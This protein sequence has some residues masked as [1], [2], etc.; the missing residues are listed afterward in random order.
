VRVDQ[1][2]ETGGYLRTRLAKVKELLETIGDAFWTEQYSNPSAMAAHYELTAGEIVAAFSG[3]DYVFVGVSTAA[4][5]R[6]CRGGSR[7]VSP[8]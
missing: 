8:P 5:S 4:R 2:D 3:L 7:S 1:R 6:G